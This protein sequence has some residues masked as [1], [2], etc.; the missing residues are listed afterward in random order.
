MDDSFS[1]S[2]SLPHTPNA[3]S[4]R[5]QSVS[6]ADSSVGARTP[7]T[8]YATVYKARMITSTI[9]RRRRRQNQLEEVMTPHA[10]R[11]RQTLANTPAR[12]MRL[13]VGEDGII[14]RVSP[15]DELRALSRVLA[16]E[17][18][19]RE[20]LEELN[21]REQEEPVHS[22]S[23]SDT[24][25]ATPIDDN[26]EKRSTAEMNIDAEPRTALNDDIEDMND[27][28]P[29]KPPTSSAPSSRPKHSS[30]IIHSRSMSPEDDGEKSL[31][32]SQLAIEMPRNAPNDRLSLNMPNSTRLS[33]A[34]PEFD[35]TQG[36]G[37][38]EEGEEEEQNNLEDFQ[39]QK[40]KDSN[41]FVIEVD[42]IELPDISHIPDDVAEFT[43]DEEHTEDIENEDEVKAT[44][45]DTDVEA[46]NDEIGKDNILEEN[47]FAMN[48]IDRF[49]TADDHKAYSLLVDDNPDIDADA[50]NTDHL[51]TRS[52]AT[53]APQTLL[54]SLAG[55]NQNAPLDDT[56]QK[57]VRIQ[58]H[59]SDRA[60]R[61]RT[62][63][64]ARVIKDLASSMTLRKLHPAA[65]E[66]VMEAS[67]MFFRQA[68]LDLAA[69]ARHSK[70]KTID[71]VDVLQL[72]RRQK[73]IT[74][75]SPFVLA[76]KYLPQ[77]LVDEIVNA[78]SN[79]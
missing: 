69:Y 77:E 11:A 28:T 20:K 4:S 53:P 23:E 19:V 2:P 3:T 14:Q 30:F 71:A 42:D 72:M 57:D 51:D 61:A 49:T 54:Q 34:F 32:M 66:D 15:R 41:P 1:G 38:D 16:R 35:L 52:D 62:T 78:T 56:V 79:D 7:R 68:G 33:E 60:P 36:E 8:P 12:R 47:N 46:Q 26:N 70:R 39:E 6:L 50:F 55:I 37:D 18:Q 10:L 31:N 24:S 59:N 44:V 43:I 17:K 25:S 65:L 45:V 67:E 5:R 13:G 63:V 64:P 74:S 40:P 29:S 22:A 21:K 48:D 27:I 9:R 58:N 76:R 73:A 75:D